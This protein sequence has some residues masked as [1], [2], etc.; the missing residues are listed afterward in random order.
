MRELTGDEAVRLVELDALVLARKD[1]AADRREYEALAMRCG[2]GVLMMARQLTMARADLATV[3]RER[4]EARAKIEQFVRASDAALIATTQ[5]FVALAQAGE[6]DADSL[7]VA[8]MGARVLATQ[9]A[10]RAAGSE[11][12]VALEALR[13]EV[14]RG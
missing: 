12:V 9:E 2:H 6:R 14:P 3:T 13:A 1:R 8:P 11:L 7:D 5:H 4:D 10:S